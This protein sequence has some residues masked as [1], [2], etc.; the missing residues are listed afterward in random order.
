MSTEIDETL[1][2]LVQNFLKKGGKLESIRLHADGRWTH[3][4]CDFENDRIVKLFSRSVGRTPGGTWVLEIGRFTYPIEV[5]DTGYF[6]DKIDLGEEPP[7]LGI[8]DTSEEVLDPSTLSYDT[9]GRLYC[10]IKRGSF[11][12]RFK[13]HPYYKLADLMREQ[14][15]KIVLELGDA[16]IPLAAMDEES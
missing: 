11:R 15:G 6:V 4:G 7:R 8:S 2:E 3:E 16:I 14:D 12:A 5:D 13:R 1:P 10:T 9:G